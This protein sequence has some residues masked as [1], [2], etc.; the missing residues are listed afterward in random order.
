ML[1]AKDGLIA[2]SC[3]AM[4]LHLRCRTVPARVVELNLKARIPSYS[5]ESH[6]C[7]GYLVQLATCPAHG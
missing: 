7:V 5:S 3:A 6:S 1:M 2:Q 4:L